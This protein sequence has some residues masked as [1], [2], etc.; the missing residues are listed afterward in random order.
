MKKILIFFSIIIL[1]TGCASRKEAQPE[2]IPDISSCSKCEMLISETQFAS[3]LISDKI[4]L[5]DDIGCMMKFIESNKDSIHDTCFMD[6]ETKMWIPGKSA[7]F[8]KVSTISTPMNYGFIAV[9]E[10]SK[11]LD[12]NFKIDWKGNWNDFRNYFPK[13]N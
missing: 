12:G 9:H 7:T 13:N 6:Y 2:I 10:K 11:L 1:L 8:I 5:F 4:Y 3:Y